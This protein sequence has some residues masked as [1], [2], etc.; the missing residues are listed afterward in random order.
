M[1]AFVIG[2]L[3]DI[4]PLAS[5]K[6]DLSA[7]VWGVLG[8]L[9]MYFA[10]TLTYDLPALREIKALLRDR[11]GPLLA[12]CPW[13][14]LLY[15]GVLAG[16]TEEILFR[17]C[18][19]PWLEKDWGWLG[20]LVFSNLIFALVHWITPLYALLAG[21]SGLYL[22]LALDA[23]D[24]RNLLTPLLIHTLYDFLAFSVVAHTYRQRPVRPRDD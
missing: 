10:F 18:L 8:T 13:P 1:I 7:V 19:Q 20:G 2:A 4:D 15:L 9:P 3:V 14:A 5:L 12:A 21:L 24:E 23:G 17:G 22:G 6:L 11:L 16:V